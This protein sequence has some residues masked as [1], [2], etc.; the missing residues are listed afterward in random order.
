VTQDVVVCG[1]GVGGLACARALERLGLTVLVLDRQR[2]HS[3][4]AK[5]ELLQPES[6]RILDGLAALPGLLGRGAVPV[7]RLAIR[8]PA[9]RPLL[10]LDYDLVPGEYRQILSADYPAVLSAL[11]DSLG[12]GTEVRR[13]ALVTGVLR[14]AR[15]RVAG[16][17]VMQDGRPRDVRAA[18]VIAADGLSSRL[19]KAAGL[20]A[21]R[22]PYDHR[23]LAF[24]LTGAEVDPE[25]SA[26]RTDRGLRLAYPLPHGR[27]RLYVQVRPEEVRADLRADPARWCDRLLAEM[28]ALA[29]LAGALRASLAGRQVLGVYRLA[30]PKLTVPGLALAG[31]A[32]HAVHPM[33]AQGMNSS[34][35]DADALAG[36][37]AAA[38]STEPGALDQALQGYQQ[39][40]SGR[41]AHT[42][43]VSHNAARMLTVT[44]GLGQVLGRRMMRHT[45][46]NSRLL[47]ATAANLAGVGVHPLSL[48]D[49][50]YQLG[51]LTDPHRDGRPA[52]RDSVR[53]GAR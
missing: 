49:R 1:A 29:P 14:D 17:T 51:L 37:V 19:R 12:P 8:D 35:A 18:L 50:L 16:V 36:Q 38:G 7:S 42:A 5:G 39:A 13:G 4:V 41:L 21:R 27:A 26:Y 2:A 6:V 11:A 28:P 32:A 46:A 45:A 10:C 23:L 25:V 30:V 52:L 9:G 3:G 43:T 24:E 20:R 31:E 15:G 44:G 48:A 34:L 22:R 33:A 53:D 47:Q 40:R